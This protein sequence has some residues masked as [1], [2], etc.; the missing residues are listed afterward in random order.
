MAA[1][2]SQ[3]LRIDRLDKLI[4]VTVEN[5]TATL[6]LLQKIDARVQE[7]SAVLK[8]HTAILKDHTAILMEHSVI[9]NEHSATLKEHSAILKEHSAILKEH[10]ARLGNLEK[11]GS[12]IVEELVAI[13]DILSSPRGMGF[14][15][16]PE[17]KD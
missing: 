4:V 1:L 7:H 10:S 2:E 12:R 15:P 5:Q 3:E 13:K 8:E 16:E 9:L 17:N 6:R 14:T 11:L